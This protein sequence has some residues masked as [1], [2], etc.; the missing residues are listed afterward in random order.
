MASAMLG[1]IHLSGHLDRMSDSQRAL[2]AEALGV[3]KQSIRPAIAA[4]EPFWPLGLPRWDDPWVALGLR[5]PA[6]S[7]LTIWRRWPHQASGRA[8][9]TCAVPHLRQAEGSAE[10][11]YPSRSAAEARWD[12]AGG[13]LSV[14]LPDSPSACVL[15]IIPNG[16]G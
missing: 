11:L 16:G 9:V 2:V 10:M 3:Y 12:A 15:R 13:T 6:V 8:T 7:Y 4:A 1:R 14:T 5:T